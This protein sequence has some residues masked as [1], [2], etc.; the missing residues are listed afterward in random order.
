[1]LVVKPFFMLNKVI[2][3]VKGVRADRRASSDLQSYGHPY[4]SNILQQ[5]APVRGY[6]TSTLPRGSGL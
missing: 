4:N 6:Q 3:H 1:M 5:F 2:D